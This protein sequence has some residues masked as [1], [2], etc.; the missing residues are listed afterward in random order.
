M[1]SKKHVKTWYLIFLAIK[2]NKTLKTT[3]AFT[4]STDLTLVDHHKK[5]SSRDTIP[6][7]FKLLQRQ[8]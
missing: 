2:T 5:Y 6:L 4:E 8:H 7:F 3:S 1:F